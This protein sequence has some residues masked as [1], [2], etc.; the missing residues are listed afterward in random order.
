MYGLIGG[1]LRPGSDNE[2][3][4][5]VA[6][7]KGSSTLFENPLCGSLDQA[8]VGALSEYAKAV[9]SGVTLV[10]EKTWNCCG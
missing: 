10:K 3:R 5:A 2:L 8:R 1:E 4:A 6:V 9:L 7:S